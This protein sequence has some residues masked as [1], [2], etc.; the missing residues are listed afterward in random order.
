[1]N[2]NSD[3]SI[4]DP[5]SAS[6]EAASNLAAGLLHDMKTRLIGKLILEGDRGVS[7]FDLLDKLDRSM[8]TRLDERVELLK[9]AEAVALPVIGV[10]GMMNSGKSTL[11]AHLL[12]ASGRER[13]LTGI[14]P[15]EGTHRFVLW[16]P[17]S[18]KTDP[19]KRRSLDEML[20]MVFD[21]PLEELSGEKERAAAQ[22]NARENRERDFGIPLLAFDP[23]LDRHG[24]ALLDCPDIQRAHQ[25]IQQEHSA[26]IR[27]QM[28]G[29][30]CRLCSAF[31]LVSSIEQ[32]EDGKVRELA[33]ATG[34]PASGLP[35]YFVLTKVGRSSTGRAGEVTLEVMGNLG[36]RERVRA[37]YLDPEISLEVL[38]GGEAHAM[39]GRYQ[40]VHGQPVPIH[41]VCHELDHADLQRAYLGQSRGDLAGELAVARAA[42]AAHAGW[43]RE[44]IRKARE[45]LL[46]FLDHH[47]NGREKGL[48]LL[49][50]RDV[51]LAL[52]GSISRTAPWYVKPTLMISGGL[53][54]AL[55]TIRTGGRKLA[56]IVPLWKQRIQKD[57]PEMEKLAKVR[58]KDLVLALQDRPWL[59]PG[60]P[61]ESIGRAWT[62]AIF[63]MAQGGIVK[64]ETLRMELDG[65]MAAVWKEVPKWK[66]L[67][68]ALAAPVALIGGLCAVLVAPF[69]LGGTS[70][71]LAAS[72]AELLAAL[73]LGIVTATAAGGR[74]GATMEHH[75]ARPQLSALFGYLQDKMGLPRANTN[76]L[77]RAPEN[78]MKLA[79]SDKPR[80]DPV[81]RVL[82]DPVFELD[83][84]AILDMENRL[85]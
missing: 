6:P 31:F 26:G 73:G 74:L 57:K 58:E 84:N 18:W 80:V 48:R 20:G 59:P 81:F 11:V 56:E 71:V 45:S 38:E 1:M 15:E 66:K 34:G 82:D 41:Q 43:N 67:G 36:L 25:S 4:A 24:L 46:Q 2:T 8:R 52:A 10:C 7:L 63:L 62:D 22:Y 77:Q 5:N 53:K 21:G 76:E 85:R 28:L 35:L 50:D 55:E 64:D 68:M 40:H 60:I 17:M 14:F 72:T 29:K 16:V 54:D 75:A 3:S 42:L 33:D 79:A 9:S 27:L 78:S 49:Y 83:E 13:V 69:D 32:F 51:V 65:A 12:S 37:I 30:A 19:Q 61:A 47:F 44:K 23:A 70:V 39:E